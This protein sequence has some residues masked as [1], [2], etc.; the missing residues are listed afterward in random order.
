M[1]ILLTGSE[2]F[3][4]KHLQ[5]FLKKQKH[6]VMCWD[7]KLG[8]R[9]SDLTLRS[10][11]IWDKP[12][13]IDYIIHL[14]AHAG[15]KESVK[16]P[17]TYWQ[18]NT[19]LSKELFD[20]AWEKDIPLMY[21]SSSCA[22]H[23]WLSPYGASKKAMETCS[24]E[25]QIGLRFSTVYGDGAREDMFISK[26]KSKTLEYYTDQ[27]RDFI[28]VNDV[29]SAIDY[30]MNYHRDGPEIYEIGLGNLYRIQDIAKMCTQE[31]ELKKAMWCEAENNLAD[32]KAIK[33][34]GWKPKENLLE[35]LGI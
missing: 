1:N 4:G 28:H 18:N 8:K 20:I 16:N 6:S 2:G 21:A 31:A 27:R 25:G 12:Y 33:E 19:L 24:Y 14:A 35:Y 3:I 13:K 22:K 17:E 11:P 9:L 10:N 15:V 26:C 32:N 23:W 7:N 30:V 5:R 34:L 29:V